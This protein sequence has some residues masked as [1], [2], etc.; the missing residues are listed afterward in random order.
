MTEY[1]SLTDLTSGGDT[2]EDLTLPS[3]KA[4]RVRGL[5]R[6][7]WHLVGKKAGEDPDAGEAKFLSI[8]VVQPELTD[9]QADAWRKTPGAGR[10]LVAVIERIKE[11]TG[12][13]EGA[14]KSNP[15]EVRG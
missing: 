14:Q 10:D 6:Y 8:G 7:E 2:G 9:K 13:S 15:D 1:A 5:S 4:V 11:L 3:G 12:V